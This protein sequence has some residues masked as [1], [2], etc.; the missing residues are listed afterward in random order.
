MLRE[1]YLIKL[2]RRAAGAIARALQ[3]SSTGEQLEQ[4]D[5]EL[6]EAMRL[7]LKLP[8]STAAQLDNRTLATM[9]DDRRTTRLLARAFFV[10]GEIHRRRGDPKQARA[11]YRRAMELYLAAEVGDDPEDV[12][13]AQAVLDRLEQDSSTTQ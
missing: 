12:A 2:I 9:M 6:S 13:T 1:D 7:L 10:E 8:R 3:L 4:A 5:R 11:S